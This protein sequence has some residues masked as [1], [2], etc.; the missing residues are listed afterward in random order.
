MKRG[1]C[2]V[3]YLVDG[4]STIREVKYCDICKADICKEC[5]GNLPKRAKAAGMRLFN[6]AFKRK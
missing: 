6:K 4:D 5:E 1:I 3:H 2:E